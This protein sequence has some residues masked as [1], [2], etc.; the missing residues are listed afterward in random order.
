MERAGDFQPDV[1]LTMSQD[2]YENKVMPL[3]FYIPKENIGKWKMN[4]ARA[5]GNTGDRS[6]V[7]ILAQTLSDN[8]D[9]TV[10]GMCAWSLG[11]L[12]GTKAKAALESRLPQEDGLV[13]EEINLALEMI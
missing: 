3:M 7:T 11:R 6:H 1:L 2:H 4:A 10:R 12:G 5:L 13:Q 9:E 8:P